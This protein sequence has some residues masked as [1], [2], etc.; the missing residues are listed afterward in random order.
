MP[1]KYW[2]KIVRKRRNCKQKYIHIYDIFGFNNLLSDDMFTFFVVCS[3]QICSVTNFE[4]LN[5]RQSKRET[6]L[7]DCLE[8]SGTK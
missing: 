7:S 5:Y 4:L 2:R 1:K 6:A 3:E 8:G